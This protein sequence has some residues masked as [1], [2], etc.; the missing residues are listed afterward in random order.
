MALNNWN[1]KVLLPELRAAGKMLQ[2]KTYAG[3]AHCFCINSGLPAP[4][5]QPYPSWHVAAADASRDIDAF[6]RRYLKTQPKRIDARLL[7]YVAVR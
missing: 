4:N 3:Q 1:D 7:T 6:C 5:I 2:V